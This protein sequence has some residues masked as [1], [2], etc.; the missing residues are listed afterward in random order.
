MEVSQHVNEE[1]KHLLVQANFFKG[2]KLW[3]MEDIMENVASVIE[4]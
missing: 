1:F 4:L 2:S 3:D